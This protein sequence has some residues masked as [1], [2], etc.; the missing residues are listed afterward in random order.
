MKT[1][2][3][4]LLVLV[5]GSA[6]AWAVLGEYESS[7]SSDQKYLRGEVR[8]M[9]LQGYSVQQITGADR[10]VVKEYVSP[11]G[12]VFG[13]S[14]QGPTMPDLQQLLGSSFSEFQ[15]AAQSRVRRRGPLVLRTDRL[16][17]ESGGHLRSFHGRAYLPSLLPKNIPAEVVR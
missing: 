9:A 3:A 5:L 16:V 15:Q 13:I 14:W 8:A 1:V 17:V 4:A 12:L 11:A 7:V 2:L 10:T 6:P